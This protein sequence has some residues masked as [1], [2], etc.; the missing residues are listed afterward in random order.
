MPAPNRNDEM[1]A[2]GS[3]MPSETPWLAMNTLLMDLNV[4]IIAMRV[5]L[6]VRSERRPF[7]SLT[8]A[9]LVE[10]SSFLA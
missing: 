4:L 5:L 10:L 6:E 8:L 3:K 2:A 9:L 1:S 7:S